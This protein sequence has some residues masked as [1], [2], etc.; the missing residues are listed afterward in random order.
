MRILIRE[1]LSQH[2][3]KTPE[4]YLICTDA[5][6][7]RTGYQQYMK[8]E[9]FADAKNDT[10]LVD[11]YRD[12]KDVFEDA[13]MSSYENK[14]ITFEHPSVDVNTLN[15]NKLSIGY[16]RNIR[17]GSDSGQDV[18]IGDLVFTNNDAIEKIENGEYQQLSCGYDCDIVYDNG[19]YR[20]INIRGNHVAL[21][22]EGRA[23]IARI[24]DSIKDDN[25]FTYRNVVII[26]SSY[27]YKF[28]L[29]NKTYEVA[30]DRDAKELIDAYLDKETKL[31]TYEI[32]F[33][34]SL[35]KTS[36]IEIKAKSKQEAINILKRQRGK[37]VYRVVECE[38]LDE[39][40]QSSSEKAFKHN[41]KTEIESGKSQKQAV[42]IAYSIKR[43]HDELQKVIKIAKFLSK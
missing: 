9:L 7:S 21:C 38:M 4:G 10:T 29:G 1:K 34:N 19:Q 40:I 36:I 42:A 16:V 22:K 37:D 12:A 17:K 20:Q 35:D 15:Y 39:L 6:L 27:G 43:K 18:M 32:R 31:H 5:I 41:V 14:P 23:G 8:S 2:K 33:I 24:V 11:V 30:T 13:A 26:K 3:Y 25:S 28:I